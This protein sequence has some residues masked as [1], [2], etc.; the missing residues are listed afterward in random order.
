MIISGMIFFVWLGLLVPINE[1]DILIG[2]DLPDMITNIIQVISVILVMLPLTLLIFIKKRDYCGYSMDSVGLLLTFV[3][4]SIT[5][6][7]TNISANSNYIL[8][9][10]STIIAIPTLVS[11][12]YFGIK[13]LYTPGEV[14]E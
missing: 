5:L 11:S 4:A 7:F 14:K 1:A 10:Q 3:T 13:L 8:A 6:I 2:P 12:I 9:I